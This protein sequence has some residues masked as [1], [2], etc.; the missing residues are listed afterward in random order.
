[1]AASGQRLSLRFVS[2]L[3]TP[4]LGFALLIAALSLVD[5]STPLFVAA[6][7]ASAS[8]AGLLTAG[9][10]KVVDQPDGTR[11]ALTSFAI[12]SGL[13]LLLAL[14]MVSVLS[15]LGDIDM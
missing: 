7:A 6:T 15:G 2:V 3:V 14:W 5:G 11:A 4:A 13:A 12:T 9:W 8:V 1:M 10:A